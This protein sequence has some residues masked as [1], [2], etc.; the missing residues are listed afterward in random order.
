[1]TPKPLLC[2]T[3]LWLSCHFSLAQA[4]YVATTAPNDGTV[5]VPCYSSIYVTL[6]FP[7][8]AETLDPITLHGR[9]VRLYPAGKGAEQVY[10]E[11]SYQAGQRLLTLT[12]RSLMMPQTTYVFEVTRELVDSRGFA[13][14]PFQLH[15]RTDDCEQPPSSPL[16]VKTD[17]VAP[18]TLLGEWK[19]QADTRGIRLTWITETEFQA[20]AFL[21]ERSVEDSAF[22]EVGWLPAQGTSQTPVTYRWVDTT[23]SL[24]KH[25]Y[26]L[27]LAGQ[28]TPTPI[29]DTLTTYREGVELLKNV[30]LL[31]QSLQLHFYA[32]K[33]TT[34]VLILR[35][36]G[37]KEVKRK[38]GFIPAGRS[39]LQ[40]DLEGVPFGD[41]AVLVST[42]T[43]QFGKGLRVQPD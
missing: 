37:G 10:A 28:G 13:F 30:L 18:K 43:V 39:D 33:K 31:G 38:A 32:A 21:V 22:Q 2:V 14:L 1:M 29:G 11:L 24:G 27:V 16:L 3:L 6:M 17:S 15:F 41:Y 42:P 12:P 35:A 26:R 8:E 25:A 23:Q 5:E 34:Y 9:S 7:S 36:R 40:I 4:P 20:E 19:V